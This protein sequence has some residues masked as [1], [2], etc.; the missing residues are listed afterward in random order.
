MKNINNY[1]SFLNEYY[2]GKNNTVGFRYSNADVDLKL[3]FAVAVIDVTL[4][5]VNKEFDFFFENNIEDFDFDII[6]SED[7]EELIQELKMISR[8]EFEPT[9]I[10]ECKLDFKGYAEAEAYS[11]LE[12][13]MKE[14]SDYM[15]L[16][17]ELN[18]EKIEKFKYLPQSKKQI[19]F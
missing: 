2:K 3:N 6:I 18:G 19:G 14:K 13:F 9:N 15:I 5:D 4:D 16:P 1:D 12:N 17:K 8:G 7:E 10:Y 11:L